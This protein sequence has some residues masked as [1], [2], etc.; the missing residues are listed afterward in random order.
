MPKKDTILRI[1]GWIG[2]KETIAWYIQTYKGTE[3]SA[4]NRLE[5]YRK[6][7]SCPFRKYAGRIQYDMARL[8]KW[9]QEQKA[10]KPLRL[11]TAG[12]SASQAQHA[13]AEL[14]K[15]K[16][17]PSMV[18]G[19]TDNSSS[20]LSE[21]E[22]AFIETLADPNASPVDKGR[23]TYNLATLRMSAAAREGSVSGS[24]LAEIS[25][26]LQELRRS[27]EA[28]MDIEV[29]RGDL[30]PLEMCQEIVG[31]LVR[32]LND[33]CNRLMARLSTEVEIWRISDRPPEERKRTIRTWVATQ[34]NEVK[35]LESKSTAEATEAIRERIETRRREMK[36]KAQAED[37]R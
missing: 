15:L 34:F 30:V 12:I 9:I 28:Y 22:L 18:A 19:G 11:P 29:R 2:A 17:T 37:E 6:L 21:H 1:P 26:A 33:A 4:I 7:A 35:E 25:R 31:E 8:P 32:R 16:A 3:R 13:L 10:D 14:A 36:G 27:E 24:M 20:I 5:Q 23:A